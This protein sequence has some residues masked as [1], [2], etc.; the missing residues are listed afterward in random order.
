MLIFIA[1]ELIFQQFGEKVDKISDSLIDH[2]FN[3][4]QQIVQLQIFFSVEMCFNVMK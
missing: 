3:W 2:L 4:Q 1:V